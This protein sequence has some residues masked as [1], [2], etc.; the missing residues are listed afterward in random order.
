LLPAVFSLLYYLLWPLWQ[1]GKHAL[2]PM[3]TIE[4]DNI[5]LPQRKLRASRNRGDNVHWV[6][7]RFPS[8]TRFLFDPVAEAHWNRA[9]VGGLGSE[10]II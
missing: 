7:R 10:H 9:R 3:R 5:L 6:D 4:F 1:V 8:G 2:R